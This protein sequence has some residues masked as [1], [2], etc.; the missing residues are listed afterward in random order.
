M[1]SFP[2]I[3]QGLLQKVGFADFSVDFNEEAK[4]VSIIIND[5]EWVNKKIPSLVNEIEHLCR[6]IAKKNN[7]SP[8]FIDI[9]N[10]RKEREHLIVE[11][12]KAAARKA[13]V[14]KKEVNLP[15]MNA[16]ERRLVHNELSTRPDITTSSSGEGK[17]RF[18]IVKPLE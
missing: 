15:P 10:Y 1:N 13:V 5:E 8:I 9:N 16:Y 6:L 17:E 11:L 18:V 4:K 3:I 2:S 12:A 14:S 7:I